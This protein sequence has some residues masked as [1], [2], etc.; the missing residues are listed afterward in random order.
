VKRSFTITFL[1]YRL[2]LSFENISFL[3]DSVRLFRYFRGGP[4]VENRR[5]QQIKNMT[6]D[7]GSDVYYGNSLQSSIEPQ[8][9]SHYHLQTERKAPAVETFEDEDMDIYENESEV[10]MSLEELLYSSSSYH[11]IAQP[12]G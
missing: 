6:K 7:S 9:T 8:V 11:A 5:E 10:E 3:I 1:F 12:G 4:Y 2:T